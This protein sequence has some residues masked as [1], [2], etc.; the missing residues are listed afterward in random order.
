MPNHKERM[1]TPRQE[2]FV[3]YLLEQGADDASV[4]YYAKMADALRVARTNPE[5]AAA[6]LK[7]SQYM[8]V[9]GAVPPGLSPQPGN[10]RAVSDFAQS[11][12][13][14]RVP[15]SAGHSPEYAARKLYTSIGDTMTIDRPYERFMQH[16]PNALRK[17]KEVGGAGGGGALA[18]LKAMGASGAAAAKAAPVAAAGVA[19]GAG[20]GIGYGARKGID[21]ATGGGFSRGLERAGGGAVQGVHN[22]L[23]RLRR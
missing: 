1:M 17:A 18:A 4:D 14:F 3:E 5:V 9:S 19:G 12:G 8:G 21:A 23:S 13:R 22:M 11:V 16:S 6:L 7:T 20:A 15:P 10:S 2:G